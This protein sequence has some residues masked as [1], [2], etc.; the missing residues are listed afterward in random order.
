MGKKI[1]RAHFWVRRKAHL[2]VIIVL[3]ILILLLFFNEDVSLTKSRQYDEE[4]AS[5]KRAIKLCE[6]S[7][8]YYNA[9][10]EELST[11]VEDLERLARENYHMQRPTE[12]VYIIK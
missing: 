10:Y 9:K 5:L 7:T 11:G 4:I 3:G 8:A 6:D 2:P 1:K 12:D